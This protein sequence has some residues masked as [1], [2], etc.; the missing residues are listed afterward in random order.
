MTALGQAAG[1]TLAAFS[2]AFLLER[3][4]KFDRSLFRVRDAL[5]LVLLGALASALVSAS[6]GVSVLYGTHVHAYSGLGSAWL[7]Y[8]LGDA[9]GVLL[10]TPV[11]LTL[12]RLLQ[13]RDRARITEIAV[14]VFL[15]TAACFLIFGDPS[16]IAAELHVLAFA[17]LPFVIWGAIRFGV[18][19]AALSILLIA[20]IATVETALGS[21]PFATSTPFTNAV[22]LDVFFAVLSVTGI[23]LASAIAE[24]EQAQREQG[25]LQARLAAEQVVRASE[26]RLR[27]AQQAARIGT[28]ERDIHTGVVRWTREVEAMYGLPPGGFDG[29]TATFFENLVYPDD[30]DR[31]AQLSHKAIET[32]KPI[33]AEWRVLW[34]DGSVHW[35]AGRWQVLMNESGQPLRM[36]GVNMDVTE[37]KLGEEKLQEYERAVE[38]SGEMI[39]VV[40]RDY[41]YLIANRRYLKMRNLRMEEVVGHFVHEVVDQRV[42][43]AALKPKLDQCF[44]GEVV[45]FELKDTYPEVGERDL[46]IS[47]FPIE[48]AKGIDRVAC[49]L[50]DITERKRAEESL[51]GMTRKLIEAQ[52]QERTR[53]GRELHDDISQRLAMLAVDLEQLQE[54]SEVPLR[55]QELRKE[56]ADIS[57]DVQALSHDLHSSK[58]EYLGVVAG[59]KSWCKEFAERQ[60]IDINCRTEISRFV[61]PEVGLSLFR[62]LQ[63]AVHNVIKHSGVRRVEVQLW[64][65][66]SEIHL[67]ISD[68]GTGFDLEAALAGKGLGLTSMRERIRLVHGSISIESKPNGGTTI[69]VRVPLGSQ[70]DSWQEAV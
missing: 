35:I 38:N 61:P 24:T 16:P 70:R 39:T 62:V 10:V 27:L 19:G 69:H 48:G 60:K 68:L 13:I 18:S 52:E 34:P 15:L 44:R 2:G 6:I 12:G 23:T 65:D 14:L 66:S 21:G 63:E 40:D 4:A 29:T 28:F 59:I 7:I 32:G 50:Q 22:L 51:A 20:A 33:A 30:R 47:Y 54:P 42:F 17:V 56:I 43:Q 64:E 37:R 8:W 57:S 25:A 55:V 1:T 11:A 9:T 3:V 49:I 46:L 45:R 5:A 53:I 26:E 36:I 67:A 31:V 41:R 58:L